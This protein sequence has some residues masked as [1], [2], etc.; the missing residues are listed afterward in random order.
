[1]AP[2]G[3]SFTFRAVIGKTW[4]LY[5]AD[6]PEKVC[7]A[8]KAEGKV[9]VVF[10]MNGSSERRTTMTPKAEGG[11]RLHLHSEVRDEI[12]AKVGDKVAIT[13]RRDTDPVMVVPPPD[14]AAE[15]READALD[16]FRAMGPAMQRE[17]VA[18]IEKAKR[19]ETRLKYVTRVVERACES[20]EKKLDRERIQAQRRAAKK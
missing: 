2:R 16:A 1:V 15:L 20:R 10:S 8:L 17:L 14:L 7:R 13:L 11:Y 4:V 9:A 12:G 19:E 5:T 6:V 3:E 18:Y